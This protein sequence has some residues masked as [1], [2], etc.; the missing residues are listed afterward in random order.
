[1]ATLLL[2]PGWDDF[3]LARKLM[4][5]RTFDWIKLVKNIEV[6]LQNTQ[7]LLQIT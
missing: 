7:E 6:F 2:L 4:A 5:E 3:R 1:M